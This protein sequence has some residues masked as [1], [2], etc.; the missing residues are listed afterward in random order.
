M[1]AVGARGPGI[2]DRA[3]GLGSVDGR[4]VS[5]SGKQYDQRVAR[6]NELADDRSGRHLQRSWG[7]RADACRGGHVYSGHRS[8]LLRGGEGSTLPALIVRRARAR[9]PPI[10]PA[11]T[12]APGPARPCSAAA[13]TYIPGSGATSAAA[14]V[15]DLPAPTAWRARA[16]LPCTQPGYY[17]ATTG[18]QQRDAGGGGHVYSRHGGDLRRGGGNRSCRPYSLAGASA[19]TLA[20]PGYY[21][22]TAGASSETPVSTGYYQP[23]SGETSEIP[24]Q[25]LAILG[26]VA[27]QTVAPLENVTPFSSVKISDP[28]TGTTDTLT[29]ELYGRRRPIVR[30]RRFRRAHDQRVWRLPPHR[31]PRLRSPASSTR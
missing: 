3:R 11:R 27:G 28:N 8:D 22:A 23:N 17:V 29:I 12:A 25:S 14:E 31:E 13:G 26:T 6:G 21:V 9:P 24:A 7:E 18:R 5:I 30:R 1:V 19:P 15:T 20:Q 2:A 16:R 10:R 4:S